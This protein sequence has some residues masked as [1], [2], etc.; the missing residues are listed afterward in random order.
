MNDWQKILEPF[1]ALWQADRLTGY[2]AAADAEHKV[3]V[4]PMLEHKLLSVEGRDSDTFLQGQLSC[5]L[6][7]LTQ[8]EHLLGAHCNPKGRMISSMRV[9]ND[10]QCRTYLRIASDL[11]E[12]AYTALKKYAVFSKVTLAAADAKGLAILGDEAALNAFEPAKGLA[13]GSRAAD[14]TGV[15]LR[16]AGWLEFWG[17]EAQCLALLSQNPLRLALPNALHE[18]WVGQGLAEVRQTTSGI[19]LPQMLNYDLVDGISLKKGCYTGQEIIARLHY[20]GQSKR[21]TYLVN[22]PGAA[23]GDKVVAC[24]KPEQE[25]GELVA[26]SSARALVCL[27]VELAASVAAGATTL[28]L[29]GETQANIKWST[30]PYAIP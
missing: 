1:G 13:I 27:S 22:C 10:D 16:H 26:V 14:P 17:S 15:Y 29:K 25:A 28:A 18:L 30:Q 24:D 12:L 3:T 2:E 20:R 21:R 4:V 7:R 19:Y 8:H 11:V 6:R 23:I 5:D 9:F